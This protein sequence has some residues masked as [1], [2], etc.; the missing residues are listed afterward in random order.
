MGPLALPLP[1]T[2]FL[3][4]LLVFVGD[5]DDSGIGGDISFLFRV[6]F[7]PSSSISTAESA[8]AALGVVSL[9]LLLP[10]LRFGEGEGI[11][12]ITYYSYLFVSCGVL[13]MDDVSHIFISFVSF[14]FFFLLL[15][16]FDF[17]FC[18]L[19]L[20]LL[21]QQRER[22]REKRAV[23]HKEFLSQK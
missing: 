5:D 19:L 13:R 10:R 22:E 11:I 20:L 6:V 7:F 15:L 4:L 16:L 18:F 2:R 23:S 8:A 21:L 1:F 9:P 3:F 12:Y 17:S 14:F